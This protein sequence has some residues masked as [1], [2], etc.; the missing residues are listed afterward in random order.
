MKTIL[1][2]L[3]VACISIQLYQS[4]INTWLRKILTTI[5]IDL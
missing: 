3:L 4:Y 1:L 2:T 5:G